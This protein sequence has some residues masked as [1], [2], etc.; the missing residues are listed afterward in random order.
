ML[1][2]SPRPPPVP[3]G[4]CADG[5][6]VESI[7][8]SPPSKSTAKTIRVKRYTLLFLVLRRN[9]YM[10]MV[11]IKL[12]LYVNLLYIYNSKMRLTWHWLLH[13]R[14]WLLHGRSWLLDRRIVRGTHIK[15]IPEKRVRC[16][17][18]GWGW[19]WG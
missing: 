4:G 3:I 5:I 8:K 13:G 9:F 2:R 16:G 15:Q 18:L 1:K 6:G 12:L 7:L 14:S 10:L 17:R 11:R 19:G